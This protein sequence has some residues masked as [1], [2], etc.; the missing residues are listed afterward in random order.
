MPKV[1]AA[2]PSAQPC[3][4]RVLAM[5]VAAALTA[6]CAKP[7]VAAA[8]DAT[9]VSDNAPAPEVSPPVD[10]AA[11]MPKDVPTTDVPIADDT[12]PFDEAAA[13]PD[14]P[15]VRVSDAS[16]PSAAD[17]GPDVVPADVAQADVPQ[18]SPL[19]ATGKFVDM[20]PSLAVKLATSPANKATLQ[21]ASSSAG[22]LID[23]DKD[24]LIDWVIVDGIDQA[25]W[26]RNIKP[27]KWFDEPLMKA[28]EPG[29]R[30]IAATDVDG[31]GF[32]EIVLGG[33]RLYFLVRTKNETY[34]DEASYRGLQTSK[35]AHVQ[36]ITTCDV[37][38]DGL[39][40]LVTTEYSCSDA[41]TV[42][43]FVNQGNGTYADETYGLG[44]GHKSTVWFT[45]PFDSDSDNHIDLLIG[46]ENCEP[47]KGNI[48]YH[49]K[50]FVLAPPHFEQVKVAPV[51][52]APMAGGV[53]PMG[54]SVGD[55]DGDGSLDIVLT[56]T[57]M[58]EMISGGLSIAKA[59][60][61]PAL[62]AD[63][64]SLANQLLLHQPDGSYQAAGL[65]WGLGWATS[66][67]AKT[68]VSWSARFLDFDGDG[69]QDLY[70]N[71]GDNAQ[72]AMLADE[73]GA[74]PVL[75]RNNGLGQFDDVSATF[76]LPTKHMSRGLSVADV[77][78]D[79]DLDLLE[80]A[81]D[82]QPRFFHNQVQA[83]KHWLTVGLK[84]VA[85][86]IWGIG[87]RLQVITSGKTLVTA[88][89]ASAPTQTADP[90]LASFAWPLGWQAKQ[91]VV[92]WPSGYVQT[93]AL[94][95]VDKA[96]VIEEPPLVQLSARFVNTNKPGQVVVTARAFD[97]TGVAQAG[98]ATTVELASNAK[99]S[100]LGPTQCA[101][102]GSCTR[103]WLPVPNGWG[104]D[105]VE[106][107]FA[108]KK[109]A[110]RPVIRFDKQ[111]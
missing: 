74:R 59:K 16:T 88:M 70:I 29:L 28:K 98:V 105:A 9:T 95:A 22:M 44:I 64:A 36:H 30:S 80:G 42:R 38:N 90:A 5:L 32:P 1:S 57:G 71:H 55:A 109:L 87:A 62:A 108:G 103:T 25:V 21:E 45:L 73:G 41:A 65:Q 39:L 33:G 47:A 99:G 46:H 15:S 76:G 106:I 67:T 110:V 75:F 94:G 69:W 66:E 104:A 85:S 101:A 8:T 31:D 54:G 82:G 91:V 27:W 12:P 4:P 2:P 61:N 50:G 23:L 86:N 20:W 26:G 51:F 68:M 43:G 19:V 48:W 17:V 97:G 34:V 52:L 63:Y 35:Q 7:V 102:D 84:G 6:H 111:F 93:V 13:T 100:W 10:T 14:G 56:S 60:A 77:D 53:T 92:H 18:A 79:G 24:N 78:G 58:S 83:N 107:S 3:V 81:M 72:S 11:G 49:N 96:M 89:G 37:D 40:D